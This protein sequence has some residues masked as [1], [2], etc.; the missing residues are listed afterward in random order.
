MRKALRLACVMTMIGITPVMAMDQMSHYIPNAKPV[1]EGRFSVMF[2]DV[3][4]ATLYAP[5]GKWNI[6]APFALRLTYLRDI[7]GEKIADRSVEQMRALGFDDEIK[8]ADWHSQMKNIFPDVSENVSLTGIYTSEGASIFFENNKEI[9]RINDP[10]FGRYFFNIW[11]DHK[12]SAPE[13]RKKLLGH[14]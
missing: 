1:G 12:T 14:S 5:D 4:D 8:L 3:Y 9:G 6:G 11:L 13:L 2:W 7:D 10:D